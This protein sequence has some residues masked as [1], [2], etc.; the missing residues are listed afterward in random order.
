MA[1]S[2]APGCGEARDFYNMENPNEPHNCSSCYAHAAGNPS[3]CPIP[4][5]DVLDPASANKSGCRCY[6][7]KCGAR[8]KR[9]SFYGIKPVLVEGASLG[10]WLA[11]AGGI[12]GG[13]ARVTRGWRWVGGIG[14]GGWVAWLAC[15][16]TEDHLSH[17]GLDSDGQ[18]PVA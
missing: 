11:A 2:S 17:V 18:D 14:G 7:C 9:Y 4:E 1:P 5:V 8:S 15:G 12:G 3:T 6:R 10:L 13:S 16:A